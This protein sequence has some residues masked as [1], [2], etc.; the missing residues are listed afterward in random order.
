MNLESPIVPESHKPIKNCKFCKSEFTDAKY[1]HNR[2]ICGAP[3][4]IEKQRIEER[5]KWTALRRE[6]QL[7][8]TTPRAY[9]V[10][11]P[12]KIIP[13]EGFRLHRKIGF[14]PLGCSLHTFRKFL[15]QLAPEQIEHFRATW[16]ALEATKRE[17]RR[18]KTALRVAPKPP[19]KVALKPPKKVAFKPPIKITEPRPKIKKKRELL[20]WPTEAHAT[21]EPVKTSHWLSFPKPPPKPATVP[22]NFARVENGRLVKNLVPRAEWEQSFSGR[23]SVA[24]T[25]AENRS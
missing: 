4:C 2:I 23:H 15:S 11:K 6:R 21:P 10:P 1:S 14:V 20:T 17:K 16:R 24:K 22:A 7:T 13:P 9:R 3:E 18:Q 5:D 25:Q 8:K 19:K 12:A